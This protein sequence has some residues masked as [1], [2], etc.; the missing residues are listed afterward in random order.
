MLIVVAWRVGAPIFTN[1]EL[2]QP[3]PDAAAEPV[4]TEGRDAGGRRS[5]FVRVLVE[6]QADSLS[7]AH[8]EPGVVNDAGE[9][10]AASSLGIQEA[11]YANIADIEQCYDSWRRVTPE[12]A[13]R[14]K[15][16]VTIEGD[17]HDGHVTQVQ[18]GGDAG[19][20]NIAFEGCVRSA[21]S[22]WQFEAPFDGGVAA[23]L[24]LAF[25]KPPAVSE[26]LRRFLPTLCRRME[27][28]MQRS[29]LPGVNAD[30][31]LYW[32]LQKISESEPELDKYLDALLD[33]AAPD[34]QVRSIFKGALSDALGE[35]W[36][37]PAFE[38][39]ISSM[40]H[41]RQSPLPSKP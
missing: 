27:E 22:S 29:E 18:L 16:R 20:G 35:A 5:V 25:V 11:A 19:V 31:R 14:L 40:S 3:P 4:E 33:G 12:L 15:F 39:L 17:G 21:I 36:A 8:G 32:V 37:C 28:Q 6:T 24:T 2:A 23:G 7:V 38:A 1:S 34:F 30:E 9:R 10:F 41:S 26:S 13:G